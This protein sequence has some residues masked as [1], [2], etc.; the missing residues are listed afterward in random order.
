MIPFIFLISIILIYI[1]VIVVF[2]LCGNIKIREGKEIIKEM[3][4]FIEEY[5]DNRA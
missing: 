4:N 5:Y 2:C 1:A 3:E